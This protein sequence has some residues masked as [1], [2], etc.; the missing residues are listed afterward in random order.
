MQEVIDGSFANARGLYISIRDCD[1]E[2]AEKEAS[3]RR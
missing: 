1:R 3:Q 2:M